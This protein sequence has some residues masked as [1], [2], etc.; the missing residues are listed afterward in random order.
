M[1]DY[2]SVILVK[3]EVFIFRIPPVSNDRHRAADWKLDAPDWTGRLRV[4]AIGK[5]IELRLEDK[6][7]GASYAKC[8]I[9]TL[10]SSALTQVT[11][12]SRYFV[13][14]LKNDNGQ[15]AFVGLGFADRSDSFDFN[16]ALQDHFRSIDKEQTQ[17]NE[18]EPPKLD[19]RF[20]E[21][22][23]ITVKIGNREPST[24]PRPASTVAPGGPIP[25]I[26]PPPNFTSRTKKN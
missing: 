14:Q 17:S 16:V 13:I 6:S 1:G 8:P 2:E 19:L 7:T 26:P 25:F 12:S 10:S 18:P 5:L 3:N 21:G 4:I 24:K 9:E 23:T 11:D 22:Q 15:A 20:K